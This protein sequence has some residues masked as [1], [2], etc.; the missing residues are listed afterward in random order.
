MDYKKFAD[1]WITSWNSHDL[2]TIMS[3]YA[4]DVEITTPM[5][6]V[7]TG[8]TESSL[9]GKA[10]VRAYWQKALDRIPDLH[11]ELVQTTVGVDSVALYYH[12]VMNK[13][14]IEVMFFNEAGKVEKIVAHYSE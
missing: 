11:F 10:A 5:I 9:K 13:M 2:D 1:D 8:G 6:R 7:A 4:E 3:H 14:S 12:S